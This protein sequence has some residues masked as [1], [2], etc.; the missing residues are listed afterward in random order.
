MPPDACVFRE[1]LPVAAIPA[2]AC[3]CGICFQG[4][5]TAVAARGF[6]LLILILGLFGLYQCVLWRFCGSASYLFTSPRRFLIPASVD[7]IC[8]PHSI[9]SPF[10]LSNTV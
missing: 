4:C 3:F 6:G 5:N 8:L 1:G 7:V 10:V 9:T 2:F